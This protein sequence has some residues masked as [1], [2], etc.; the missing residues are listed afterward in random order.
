MLTEPRPDKPA[1]VGFQTV[2][3]HNELR[4]LEKTLEALDQAS[5]I[6]QS[7]GMCTGFVV[8]LGDASK[9]R[10]LS[11]ELLAEYRERFNHI[12]ELHYRFFNRNMGTARGQNSLVRMTPS[13]EYSIMGNPD[14]VV[15][16]RAIWRMLAVFN[17]PHVGAV[18]AKQQPIEH[19]KDYDLETGLTSWGSGAF[20]MTPRNLFLELGG[21]DADSFFLYCDDVDYSWRVKEAGYTVVFQP[22]AVVYHEKTL[23][24]DGRWQPTHAERY[25]SAQAALLLAHKWSRPRLVDDLIQR[26][27]KMS[28]PI[29]REAIDEFRKREREG[30]LAAPRD[31]K[32]RIG[33]FTGAAYEKRRFEFE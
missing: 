23:D 6:G 27:K 5:F 28:D 9:S 30:K 14:V 11:D 3:F 20:T 12:H 31:G 10:L 19:P 18:E 2:L 25:Y 15:E 33:V 24:T 7:E 22:S 29:Y 32:H 8:A 13:V 26:Y 1:V 17:D 16:P 21:Y 4:A